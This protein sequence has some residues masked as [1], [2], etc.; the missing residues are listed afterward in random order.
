MFECPNF[1][2]LK[3]TNQQAFAMGSLTFWVFILPV[4]KGIYSVYK[5]ESTNQQDF[6]RLCLILGY[7]KYQN[8]MCILKAIQNNAFNK[9]NSK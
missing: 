6:E 4:F 3:S 2:L 1:D 8:S 7:F 9:R 5:F